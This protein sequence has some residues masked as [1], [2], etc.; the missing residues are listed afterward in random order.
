MGSLDYTS[1]PGLYSSVCPALLALFV[2][3]TQCWIFR[4]LV[5]CLLYIF[6]LFHVWLPAI[7]ESPKLVEMVSIKRY[8]Y[9][10]CFESYKKMQEL[11]ALFLT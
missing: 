3:V 7:Q 9:F 11:T 1:V 6:A 10:W 8:N 5:L 2:S 4:A